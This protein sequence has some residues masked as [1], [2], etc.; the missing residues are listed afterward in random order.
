MIK[1]GKRQKLVVN[2][3]TPIGLYLDAGTENEEDNILLPKNEYEEME[4]KPEV[5]SELDVFIYMDSED[6]PIA[7]LRKTAATVG[8]IAK[9]EATDVNKKLGAFLDWGLKKELLLPKGQEICPIEIGKKYLVGLYEDK[10]GRISAT[11]KIYSFLMPCQDYDK[12]DIVSGTVYSIDENIGVFV[13][14]DNR[15]FGMI[16]KN[17]YFKDFKI[18]DEVTTRVIRVREDGKLD[19]T[20]RLMAYQQMD[21][22]AELIFEKMKLLKDAFY[23]NDKTSP[24]EIYEY[25]SI[26]KKAFKRA[27]GSLLKNGFI[28]KDEKGFHIKK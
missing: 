7:T 3:Y 13:A 10:K 11:M 24:E 21:K 6:R 15:Y 23:F 22:D 8:T 25:F 2:N 5:G 20:P 28:E 16:P 14:V 19:L 12:N 27:I 26:S 4:E 17:E 1:M 18:G 9:L